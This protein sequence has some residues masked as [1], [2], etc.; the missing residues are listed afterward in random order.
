MKQVVAAIGFGRLA[1]EVRHRL[2]TGLQSHLLT[3]LCYS[4]SSLRCSSLTTCI[5]TVVLAQGR[6]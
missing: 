6:S 4:G 1:D 5:L 3:V 2:E